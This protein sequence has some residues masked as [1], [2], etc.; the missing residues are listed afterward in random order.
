MA[1]RPDYLSAESISLVLAAC[2]RSGEPEALFGFRP[3]GDFRVM[4]Q[5]SDRP[6]G[7]TAG[8]A[9]PTQA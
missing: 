6:A 9:E 3:R 5:G 2:Q 4:L 7:E 1:R 8:S